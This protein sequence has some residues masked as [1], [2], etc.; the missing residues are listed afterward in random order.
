M[1][2]LRVLPCGGLFLLLLWPIAAAATPVLDQVAA[3]DGGSFLQD[4]DLEPVQSF[5]VGRTGHLTEIDL[6][7]TTTPSAQVCC[8]LLISTQFAAT[9]DL[10]SGNPSDGDFFG[11]I[12]AQVNL[13]PQGD[14]GPIFQGWNAFVLPT[15]IPV[16][17]G[18]VLY[19]T[20]IQD[21]VIDWGTSSYGGGAMAWL[22]YPDGCSDPANP[23]GPSLQ[24]GAVVFPSSDWAFRTFVPEPRSPALLALAGLVAITRRRRRRG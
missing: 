21:D 13:L 19:F 4:N 8:E 16:T 7:S 15:P 17:A 3:P 5:T 11:S 9:A 10:V 14:D 12:V 6:W 2:L 1:A 22:C 24:G 23:V 18:D 20:V